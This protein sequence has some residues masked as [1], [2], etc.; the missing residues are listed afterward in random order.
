MGLAAEAHQIQ[1]RHALG[2]RG[3]LGQQ[4]Q[5][6]GDLPAGPAMDIGPVQQDAAAARAQ[7]PGQGAEQ[8]R[9]AAAV[10]PHDGRDLAR[11][12]LQ[13]QAVDDHLAIVGHH[14]LMG[15]QGG[16]LFMAKQGLQG[17]GSIHQGRLRKEGFNNIHNR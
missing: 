8:G 2:R 9:L 6:A 10:G 1:H 4:R 13:L 17:D 15:R 5:P 11:R 7:H 12:Q 16:L 14:Q 3:V